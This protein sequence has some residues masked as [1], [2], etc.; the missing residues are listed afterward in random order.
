[1][2]ALTIVIIV[3]II[4]LVYFLLKYI[5]SNP[6]T[7][8]T[9]QNG[10]TTT[11][12]AP[13][14]LATNSGISADDTNFAYSI[15]FYINDW[16]YRYGEIKTIFARMGNESAGTNPCPAVQLDAI[17]N[18]LTV[19]LACFPGAGGAAPVAGAMAA[20]SVDHTCKVGNVPIQRWVNLIV[21]VYGRSMDIYID[22]K[23]VK[24]CL[25]PGVA[26]INSNAPIYVTPDG[27]FDGWTSKFQYYP[28]PLN[29]QEAW[30]IYVAG[31][32]TPYANMFGS[33]QVQVSLLENGNT[34]STVTV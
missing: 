33:Y 14:A 30:N 27:G 10:Q 12:I 32:S 11:V 19:T 15:W 26:N 25:L 2:N 6:Y 18:N 16:N 28:S 24:T 22:G 3:I 20:T 23:L 21:S 17:E 5:F 31:Y 8:Q 1:M 29:P 34:K 4:V 9:I 7:L 13:S